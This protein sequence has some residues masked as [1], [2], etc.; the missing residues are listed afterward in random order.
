MKK[1]LREGIFEYRVLR[2]I[3][4]NGMVVDY[5][6]T[7]ELLHSIG[8]NLTI[9]GRVEPVAA[10]QADDA[11]SAPAFRRQDRGIVRR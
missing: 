2:P 10:E 7:V 4:Y 9:A 6:D 1:V 5:P 8:V 3:F 11:E